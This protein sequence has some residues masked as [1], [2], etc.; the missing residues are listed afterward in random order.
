MKTS[1]KMTPDDYAWTVARLKNDYEP[2]ITEAIA[3]AT[4]QTSYNAKAFAPVDKGGLK[5]S[6]RTVIKGMTGEVIVGAD[7]G[8]YQEFGTGDR[9]NVPSELTEIAMQ[10]KG[11]GIRKVNM[12]AQPYLYPSFFINRGKFENDM[13]NRINKIANRNWR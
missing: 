11:K 5:S 3:V 12:R 10:Y 13:E 4:R 6:I 2:E 1:F 8:P 7:Y 9:V